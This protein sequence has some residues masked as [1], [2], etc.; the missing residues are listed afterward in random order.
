MAKESITNEDLALI[1]KKG[2]DGVDEKFEGVDKRLSNLEQGQKNLEQGQ[3][4][5]KMRLDS[6]A[7]AFEVIELDKRVKILENNHG[8]KHISA[9]LC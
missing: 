8:T 5:I 7:N 9:C 3:D 1:I 6:K 4:D 2:F